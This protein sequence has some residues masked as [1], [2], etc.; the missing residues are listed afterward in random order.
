MTINKEAV[1]PGVLQWN[2]YHSGFPDDIRHQKFDLG[3][4]GQLLFLGPVSRSRGGILMQWSPPSHIK[5]LKEWFQESIERNGAP[6]HHWEHIVQDENGGEEVG[7][8]PDKFA[9]ILVPRVQYCFIRQG[10]L[11]FFYVD[12]IIIAHR[13]KDNAKVSRLSDHLHSKYKISGSDPVQWFLGM[14]IIRDRPNQ[15]IWLSQTSYI[16]KIIKLANKRFET[17]GVPMTS[18]EWVPRINFATPIE[19]QRYQQKV[20]SIL[21]AA[22]S[23]RPYIAFA[24]SKLARFLSNLSQQHQDAADRVLWYLY[25]TKHRALRFGGD[26]ALRVASDASFAD[27]STDLTTSTTEAELLALAQAAKE[28]LFASRLFKELSIDLETKWTAIE[29]NNQAIL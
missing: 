20:E 25:S 27:N 10:V 19:F 6:P 14:E 16:D 29:Y 2:G 4:S 9:E 8:C 7:T 26:D 24:T 13:R 3:S 12:D 23:T 1:R 21:F 15:T 17:V 22:V 5:R 18:L 28:K 11:I